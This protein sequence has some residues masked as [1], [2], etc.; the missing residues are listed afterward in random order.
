MG[1]LCRKVGAALGVALLMLI[2][3]LIAI[4]GDSLLS[5]FAAATLLAV[6]SAYLLSILGRQ[7]P[8]ASGG[9]DVKKAA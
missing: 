8:P 2:S 7:E 3:T 1:H 4:V 6:G 5:V 9:G